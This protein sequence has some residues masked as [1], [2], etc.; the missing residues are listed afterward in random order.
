MMRHRKRTFTKV[1]SMDKT[2]EKFCERLVALDMDIFGLRK[3][4]EDASKWITVHPNGAEAKG[5]P[6]LI[7]DATGRILGGM[8]GKF[9]GSKIS[10]VR[11]S[12]VGPRTPAGHD[13]KASGNGPRKIAGEIGKSGYTGGML[14]SS[15][16]IFT[17]ETLQNGDFIEL[18]GK[19]YKIT[20]QN[21]PKNGKNSYSFKSESE[22]DP[23][24]LR[25][26]GF[27]EAAEKVQKSIN[28][29]L[30]GR[31]SD[32]KG[33]VQEF[34]GGWLKDENGN[35]HR[36]RDDDKFKSATEKMRSQ[37]PQGASNTSSASASSGTLKG[38]SSAGT[39]FLQE[40]GSRWT[41][42][43]YDRIYLPERQKKEF[44]DKAGIE[45]E[46][47]RRG[48]IESV[49]GMSKNKSRQ[50]LAD[51]DMYYDVK[52]GEF[53]PGHTDQRIFEAV[54]NSIEKM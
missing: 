25:E 34:V 12:F 48:N 36:E 43:D 38:V 21:P 44:F 33:Y 45:Y 16:R 37:K 22:I 24:E 5:R 54:K 46:V 41:K 39:A 27:S 30:D 47:D 29:R 7:D 2:L 19:V 53:K 8:G 49:F 17:D 3:T 40:K 42:G 14:K 13:P 35:W 20:S 18:E 9:N 15:Q 31:D 26:K 1:G 52:S 32:K 6:A 51:F 23:A 10:E 50:L 11:K 4:T 28:A